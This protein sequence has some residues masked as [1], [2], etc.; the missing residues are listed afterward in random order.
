M[1]YSVQAG[2]EPLPLSLATLGDLRSSVV[3]PGGRL[4]PASMGGSLSRLAWGVLLAVAYP[5]L[6]L[7]RPGTPATGQ[8]ERSPILSSRKGRAGHGGR[9]LVRVGGESPPGSARDAVRPGR[10]AGTRRPAR[11]D[12]DLGGAADRHPGRAAL[13]GRRGWPAAGG[14]VW[15]RTLLRQ[16]GPKPP[17]GFFLGSARMGR[18]CSRSS[19]SPTGRTRPASSSGRSAHRRALRPQGG[20]RGSSP[21]PSACRHGLSRPMTSAR[22]AE[23][24]G[25]V[26]LAVPPSLGADQRPGLPVAADP[27]PL[28]VAGRPGPEPV[29]RPAPRPSRDD[30]GAGEP[31]L[32]ARSTC[33]EGTTRPLGG[34]AVRGDPG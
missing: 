7:H 15:D 26:P 4:W 6:P 33:G 30:R 10:S 11:A 23:M 27:G 25:A 8:V 29:R 22:P 28:P 20:P 2:R 9:R 14:A 32:P 18:R 16:C 31:P 5:G 19:P 13:A 17:Q 34:S 12:R 1:P 24:P 21:G 3:A